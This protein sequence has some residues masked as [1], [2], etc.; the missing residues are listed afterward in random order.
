MNQQERQTWKQMVARSFSPRDWFS[1]E[2]LANDDPQEAN[3]MWVY[4]KRD[5]QEGGNQFKCDFWEVGY[6]TPSGG[7]E[8]DSEHMSRESAAERVHW[9]NGG[10]R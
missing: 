4:R 10:D 6:W 9:L 1:R 3:V 5:K 8:R 7:W 2:D